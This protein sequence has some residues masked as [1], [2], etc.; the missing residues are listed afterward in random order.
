MAFWIIMA[1]FPVLWMLAGN[2][3]APNEPI[4]F[5][6]WVVFG[7]LCLFWLALGTD[8]PKTHQNRNYEESEWYLKIYQS[9]WCD[10]INTHVK[11]NDF[12]HRCQTAVYVKDTYRNKKYLQVA[13]DLQENYRRKNIYNLPLIDT[14]ARTYEWMAINQIDNPL[15]DPKY[16]GIVTDE[17]KLREWRVSMPINLD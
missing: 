8:T 2:S 6:W 16:K 3:M 1:C 17:E 13:L 10:E 5:I 15:Y 11:I 14:Y 9:Y 4:T 7:A 12:V